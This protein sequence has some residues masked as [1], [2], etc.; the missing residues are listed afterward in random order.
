MQ[1]VGVRLV[2][3]YATDGAAVFWDAPD[4]STCGPDLGELK[5]QFV[6]PDTLT[7]GIDVL[8]E[9]RNLDTMTGCYTGPIAASDID[10]DEPS[11]KLYD[12]D[13]NPAT[14]TTVVLSTAA[15]DVE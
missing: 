11:V 6:D 15:S 3:S 2:S 14:Q 4:T 8:F 1:I 12:L 5:V 13:G 10:L 9:L 7:T